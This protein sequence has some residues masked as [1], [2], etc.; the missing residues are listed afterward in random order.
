MVACGCSLQISAAADAPFLCLLTTFDWASSFTGR[1]G[2]SFAEAMGLSSRMVEVDE[3]ALGYRI[4]RSLASQAFFTE[5][6]L[7]LTCNGVWRSVASPSAF[8]R[9]RQRPITNHSTRFLR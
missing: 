2:V 4:K 7:Y 6:R 9:R 1:A 5:P 8:Q 3:R